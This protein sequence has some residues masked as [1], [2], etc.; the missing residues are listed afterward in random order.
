M[1][2]PFVLLFFSPTLIAV[3]PA[4]LNPESAPLLGPEDQGSGTPVIRG[5]DAE[6]V[7]AVPGVESELLGGEESAVLSEVHDLASVNG[8]MLVRRDKNPVKKTLG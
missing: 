3:K 6:D 5:H 2:S 7:L 8:V 4:A 1:I